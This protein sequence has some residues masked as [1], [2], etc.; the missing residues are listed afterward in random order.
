[1]CRKLIF[2]AQASPAKNMWFW[3]ACQKL[4]LL[5]DLFHDLEPVSLYEAVDGFLTHTKYLRK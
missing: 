3:H 5:A 4:M 2:S 1:M